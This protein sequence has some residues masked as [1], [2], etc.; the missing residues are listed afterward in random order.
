MGSKVRPSKP[1]LNMTKQLIDA[2]RQQVSEATRAALDG[3]RV[4]NCRFALWN[5]ETGDRT[6]FD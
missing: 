2:I 5:P 1:E 3:W 4:G 6:H